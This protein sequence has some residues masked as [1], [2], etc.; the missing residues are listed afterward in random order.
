MDHLS[1]TSKN[2]SSVCAAY[3]LELISLAAYYDAGYDKDHQNVRDFWDVV[4]SLDPEEK[5]KFLFF[6]TGSDRAPI[7]GL[8]K[9]RLIIGKNGDVDK[10]PVSHTCFNHFI[11]PGYSSKNKL[12]EMLKLAIENA[13]GFGLI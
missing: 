9:L 3:D 13:T 12:R 11:L 1:L 2:L 4:H 5:K 10:L 7:G 6:A 8:S